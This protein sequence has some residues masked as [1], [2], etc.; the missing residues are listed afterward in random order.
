MS[1]DP[2]WVRRVAFHEAGHAVS[3]L[4]GGCLGILF[5]A[6]DLEEGEGMVRTSSLWIDKMRA[7][8]FYAGA[9]A[10]VIHGF[11]PYS[12]GR[13][14][15]QEADRWGE[16]MGV[17]VDPREALRE[18]FEEMA[19]PLAKAQVAALAEA[20]LERGKLHGWEAIEIVEG[21]TLDG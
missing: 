8:D 16:L 20:L 18:A 4:N 15:V 2:D 12:P 19:Q 11:T 1:A 3:F 5:V 14:D 7:Q 9:A 13:G 6:V 21:V 10:E 17:E